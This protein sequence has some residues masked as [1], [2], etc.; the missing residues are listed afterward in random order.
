MESTKIPGMWDKVLVNNDLE[1]ATKEF[2]EFVLQS[3]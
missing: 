3:K 1:K 2:I